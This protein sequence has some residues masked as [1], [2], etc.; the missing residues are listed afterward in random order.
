MSRRLLGALLAPA[1]LLTSFALAPMAVA[2]PGGGGSTGGAA[3]VHDGLSAQ[4]AAASCWDIKTQN[5]AAADGAYWLQTPTMDT[6][7]QY[8]CD[9]TTR[10]RATATP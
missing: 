5:P 6:P 7:G 8:Y 4:T 1:A 3:A 2:D 9:Q 10:G